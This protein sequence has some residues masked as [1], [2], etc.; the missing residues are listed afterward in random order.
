MLLHLFCAESVFSSED[1]LPILTSA[2]SEFPVSFPRSLQLQGTCSRHV[3]ALCTPLC[4]Q[5][6][7]LSI[8]SECSS[9][10]PVLPVSLTCTPSHK[11][12][13]QISFSYFLSNFFI[14]GCIWSW[15]RHSGSSLRVQV[16]LLA[17]PSRLCSAAA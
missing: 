9:S 7:R 6:P 17:V 16:S 5:A 12:C 1:H 2:E 15:L 13:A 8:F 11:L 10:T 3:T 4:E 14:F